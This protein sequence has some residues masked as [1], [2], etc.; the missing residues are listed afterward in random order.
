MTRSELLLNAV[1]ALVA[2]SAAAII[3]VLVVTHQRDHLT[4]H[5]LTLVDN[6]N[7]PIALLSSDHNA[8]KLV[9]FDQ[10]LRKR[11]AL[12]LEPNGTPDLYLYDAAG[13]TRVALNLYD[14]GVPNLE[15]LDTT[16]GL[17]GPS[18][19]LESTRA[20]DVRFAFHNFRKN[21]APVAG[22]LEFS[23]VDDR[24]TLQLLDASGQRLWQAP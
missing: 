17:N 23:L 4:T 3:S 9:F 20:G 13:K 7:Q 12:F 22:T 14:S 2:S 8:P 24:P 21:G 10:Q 5:E 16:E 6:R 19:L 1:V 15:L 11:S 18:V